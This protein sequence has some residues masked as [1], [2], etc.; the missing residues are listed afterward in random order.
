MPNPQIMASKTEQRKIQIIADGSS[1]NAS[2]E[3]MTKATSVLWSELKKLT[4]GSEE[5]IKKSKEF[6]E[7]KSRLNETKVAAN[8]TTKSLN[9]MANEALAMSPIGGIINTITGAM[10]KARVGVN[11]VTTS[12]HTLK[13]AIAAT[14]IGLLVIGLGLLINYLTS[15]QDGIDK[16]NKVLTPMKVI[17]EKL[18]GV[19]QNLGGNLFKGLGEMLNG[20]VSKGFSSITNGAKQAGDELGKAFTDGIKQGGELADMNIKIEQTEIALT[21]ARSVLNNKYQEAMEIAKDQ[22]KSEEQRR[23]AAKSAQA[24]ENELL[25]K[26]QEFIDMKIEKLKLEQTFNDT[27]REG[28][29]ELANLEAERT[30]FETQAS[31]RRTK[32]RSLENTIT[33]EI[34]TEQNKKSAERTKQE[35]ENIKRLS[36]LRTEYLKASLDLETQLE[37]MLINLMDEGLSKKTAKL[38]LDLEREIA[39]LDEKRIKILENETLTAEEKIKIQ[40]QFTDLEEMIRQE[41][42]QKKADLEEKEKE[43]ELEK[44]LDDF[45]AEQEIEM[46]QLENS[47]IGAIDAEMRKKEALLQIQKQYALEKLA[48]LEAAGDGETIQALK[49]KNI[50]GKIDQEI[51]DG[52][53]TEAQRAEEY[54]RQIQSVGLET[55]REFM[56]L[57]L[58]LL[59][60]DSKARKVAALAMKAFEIGLVVTSGI[61]EI[62]GYWA[63]NAGIPIIGPGLATALS[64]AAGVRTLGAVNKIRTAKYATGGQTGS[65]N[66]IDMMMGRDGAWRMPNGQG[67][68]NVGTFK[69]GGHIGSASFGVI[70]EAGSEW[71][72]PNW[73]MR[74]PKYANIFGYLE[75]ERKRATPFASGGS[76]GSAPQIPQNSS[77][78][79]DLQQSLAMIEQFGD[80][81][82]KFDTMISILQQW[83]DRLRVYNDPRDI[84]SG[85]R[86]LNEI[87]A[88]SRINR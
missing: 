60:E 72:G 59:A 62:Q 68:R 88:D 28:Y 5:F 83:P 14:G 15:T 75:A 11:L 52:K 41:N 77:A 48:L 36:Q 4:P 56:Q 61:R 25:D 19:V 37:D 86:V 38:E 74:S 73:M 39:A 13:G 29:L 55:A 45:D 35:E 58:D 18:Q 43:D 16:V 49:L 66:M 57:G 51:A 42:R 81:S 20:N 22:S 26:E 80:M 46:L 40:E 30:D 63:S 33:E 34:A 71:V 50:I 79:A 12:F 85:V 6:Q 2:M 82:A 53:I 32:A 23:A 3:Q 24:L 84:R 7:V 87:E 54:K 78:T 44:K 70:G 47:M 17:F 76:T 21:E 9:E 31:K 65:G 27:S 64:I 1:V 67:T 10:G 8:G 69:N